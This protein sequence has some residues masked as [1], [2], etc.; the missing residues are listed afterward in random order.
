[1]KGGK[2]LLAFAP[3]IIFSVA[4]HLAG[5]KLVGWA[6]LVSA[7]AGLLAI[8]LGGRGQGVPLL[9]VASTVIFSVL[10]GIALLG[11]PGGEWFVE[12]FGS[13][14][15]ALLLG[16]LMYASVHSTPFTTSYAK[17]MVDASQWQSVT[18]RSLNRTISRAWAMAVLGLGVCRV[19]TGVFEVV[20]PGQSVL[21]V[22]L[23]VGWLLPAGLILAAVRTTR[24]ATAGQS[25]SAAH[26]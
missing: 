14:V 23:V 17:A 16:A 25:T 13:G 18:F 12:H 19:A 1:M 6:A 8:L 24:R 26:S 20:A 9:S 5:P 7:A 4:G 3:L 11:G 2:L 10:G 21:L 22:H 15:S